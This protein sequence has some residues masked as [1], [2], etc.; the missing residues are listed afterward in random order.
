MFYLYLDESGYLGFNF[1]AKSR[2]IFNVII[3]A[4]RGLL[5]GL[6]TVKKQAG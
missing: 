3:L 1:I 5:A 2:Q 4:I 6:L